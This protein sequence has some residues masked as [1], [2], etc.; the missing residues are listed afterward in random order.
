MPTYTTGVKIYMAKKILDSEL[1]EP[2][3]YKLALSNEKYTNLLIKNFKKDWFSD[4]E[5]GKLLEIGVKYF[6][7]KSELPTPKTM[8]LII[9]KVFKDEKRKD[10]LI[11]I[12]NANSIDISE[13]N[14]SFLEENVLDYLKN[15][16][17]F[18]TVMRDVQAMQAT[19]T[20]TC[21]EEIQNIMNMSFSSDLGF[22]YF[23]DI[24]KHL[25]TLENPE[26]RITTGWD[27][28]DDITNGGFYKDGRCLIT[29]MAE[30]GM[31]KSLTM[32][33]IAANYIKK[34]LFPLVISLEMSEHV[35]A[36]RIDAHLSEISVND[37]KFKTA[38][39]KDKLLKIKED[40]PGANLI[41]KE[42][43]PESIDSITIKNYIEEVIRSVGRSPDIILIDYLNLVLPNGGGNTGD[44]S[45]S[46]IGKTSRDLRTLSYLFNTPV[47]TATQSNRS[48]YGSSEPSIENVSESMGIAHVTDL[49]M[50][51]YQLEGD[52]EAGIMRMM[53]LKNRLAGVVGK[54]LTFDVDYNNLIISDNYDDFSSVSTIEMDS[55]L[56]EASIE[57]EQSI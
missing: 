11:K 51:L 24:D 16:G 39:L 57:F 42:Y 46:K 28:M 4:S 33:N 41:I 9:S 36:Q 48:G 31:G 6:H 21:M 5:L 55:I 10:A 30:T 19:Q 40:Q 1:I 8:E 25:S 44:N 38:E 50:A 17:T 52:R 53:S 18:H 37:L 22:S 32:S 47:V 14:E 27:L 49:F 15:N 56:S 2:I 12:K 13:Y 35:Y 29:F 43:P 54:S 45:Y 26:E 23:D 34:G 7:S 20:V 3:I